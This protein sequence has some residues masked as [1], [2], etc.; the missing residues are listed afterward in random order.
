MELTGTFNNA[1]IHDLKDKLV[2]IVG[3]KCFKNELISYFL[4]N[5]CRMQCISYERFESIQD[6]EKGDNNEK[7]LVLIDTTGKDI[8]MLLF[9]LENEYKKLTSCF[10]M[11][12]FNMK[13]N[14]G[15]EKEALRC[16]LRGF[17][18]VNDTRELFIKGI[19]TMSR[20]QLWVSRDVLE[21]CI[22]EDFNNLTH[23]KPKSAGNDKYHLTNRELE[24]LALITV[25]TKNDE[26]ADKLF[27][28]PHTVKTHLYNVFKK[29]NVTDR[30]QAALWAAKNLQ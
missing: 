13:H 26:I 11:A 9:E 6:A 12:L 24:I 22:I 28:S 2:Y 7:N 14:T 20:G 30:L 27:I 4:F 5:E 15:I 29:I 21:Q 1:K 25:G 18:Y 23:L 19:H 8:K 3:P 10:N 16:G 17:F